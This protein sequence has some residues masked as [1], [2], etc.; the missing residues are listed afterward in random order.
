MVP[1]ILAILF[2][3]AWLRDQ[4][5]GHGRRAWAGL[6]ADRAGLYPIFGTCWAGWE[7][8]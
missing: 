3:L 8:H 4:V 5:F 6:H 1:A 2:M 7:L